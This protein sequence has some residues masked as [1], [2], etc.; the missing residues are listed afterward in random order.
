MANQNTDMSRACQTRWQRKNP[1][2]RKV[3]RILYIEVRAGRMVRPT[4][5][6]RCGLTASRIDGH[7]EDYRKPLD[8]IWLCKR[9]FRRD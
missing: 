9:T 5:C 2:K 3:H 6:S 8:V 7:H 1:E 4:E